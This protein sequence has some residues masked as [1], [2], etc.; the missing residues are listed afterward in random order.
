MSTYKNFVE[1]EKKLG[2]EFT[3]KAL[4][5]EALTHRSFSNESK[6][7][8]KSN[9]ER[10]EFLGD[11]VLELAISENLIK[12]FLEKAEGELSKA[13][14]LLVREE[15]LVKIARSINLGD[16][17]ILGKGEKLSGGKQKDSILACSLEAIIGAI[18]LDGGFA[19]ALK[20]IELLWKDMFGLVFTKEFD[21]DHKTKLQEFL[22][23][24]YKKL[25]TYEFVRSFGPEHSKLFEVKVRSIDK[26]KITSGIGKSKK[27]AEQIAAHKTF[28][29]LQEG[30]FL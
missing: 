9:Y 10:L 19:K 27:E 26:I 17:L 2:Y 11:A 3:Q 12:R 21:I 29:V 13:R 14:S 24:K 30:G 20:S 22:Q 6:N 25:P 15:L 7:Q 18:H 1:L 23:A 5:E 8:P 16:F 28:K 4:L